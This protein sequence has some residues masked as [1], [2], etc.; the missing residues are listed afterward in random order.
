MGNVWK[1]ISDE[2]MYQAEKALWKAG[3]VDPSLITAK[4]VHLG[5]SDP[6]HFIRQIDIEPSKPGLPRMVMIHGFGGGGPMFCKM[7]A[8]MRERF[9]VTTI[10]LL[11]LAGSGRPDF[12]A[13]EYD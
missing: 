12:A 3:G 5:G 6:E 4:N 2:K 10:D 8:L 13:R 9:S 7:V 1:G 11:G